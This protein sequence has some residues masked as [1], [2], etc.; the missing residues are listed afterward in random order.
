MGE[1]VV[2]LSDQEPR[3]PAY[4]AIQRQYRSKIVKPNTIRTVITKMMI[5]MC[6]CAADMRLHVLAFAISKHSNHLSSEYRHPYCSM[7]LV[8][9]KP[10]FGVSDQVPNKSGRTAA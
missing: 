10:V 6:A 4:S 1:S 9:R 8:V 7:S 3:K 5:G 2:G